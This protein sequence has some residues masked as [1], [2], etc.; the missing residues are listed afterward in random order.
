MVDSVVPLL[1]YQ[2]LATTVCVS[3]H[4][5]LLHVQ[6]LELPEPPPQY[7]AAAATTIANKIQALTNDSSVLVGVSLVRL[8]GGGGSSSTSSAAAPPAPAAEVSSAWL[9]TAA[10]YN[11]SSNGSALFSG[12]ARTLKAAAAPPGSNSSSG[13]SNATA[14][15]SPGSALMLL[16]IY[17]VVGPANVVDVAQSLQNNCPS[18][19]KYGANI[20]STTCGA[21]II[22]AYQSAIGEEAAGVASAAGQPV[23]K[24]ILRVTE[25][26]TKAASPD[27]AKA[28][29]TGNSSSHPL[30]LRL[31]SA[32]G[33]SSNSNFTVT[34]I[35]VRQQPEVSKWESHGTPCEHD[36]VESKKRAHGALPSGGYPVYNL[37]DDTVCIRLWAGCSIPAA[38]CSENAAGNNRLLGWF[39]QVN[40]IVSQ[41]VG[42]TAAQP[43]ADVVLKL[44]S[45]SS[46][47]TLP[48]VL[49]KYGLSV[50]QAGQWLMNEFRC[51]RDACIRM[52]V[53]IVVLEWDCIA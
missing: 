16:S 20:N 41:A 27:S 35:K 52:C 38:D 26:G 9:D 51:N 32:A 23:S 53:L 48:Q 17:G 34:S 28:G 14:S 29:S 21:S 37:S 39:M 30:A 5:D 19:F 44:Q 42:I 45:F 15:S 22:A 47:F 33:S 46:S 18:L 6:A 4:H 12:K 49:A 31:S 11:G 3:W 24:R 50:S 10:A 36:K 13:A 43:A 1:S 2:S 8:G 7:A 25:I 40:I